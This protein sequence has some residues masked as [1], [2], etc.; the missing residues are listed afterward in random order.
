MAG[1]PIYPVGITSASKSFEELAPEIL[2]SPAA[3]PW[4]PA[5]QPAATELMLTTPNVDQDKQ[6]ARRWPVGA[7]VGPPCSCAPLRKALA[8]TQNH[9]QYYQQASHTLAA[10]LGLEK[11]P[12]KNGIY[13]G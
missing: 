1:S 5:W 4:R 12:L 9:V 11:V 7:W 10:A 6:W 3:P 2:W 8:T 13:Q